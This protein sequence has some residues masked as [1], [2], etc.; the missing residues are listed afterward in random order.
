MP[1][2]ASVIIS[3]FTEKKPEK[4]MPSFKGID[5]IQQETVAG[6]RAVLPES[7][8]IA[9]D[10]ND[11]NLSQKM[12]A[13]ESIIPGFGNLN[14]QFSKN[15]Q[16]A[17]QGELPSDV[18]DM[19]K[20][21][22]AE[23]AA[24]GG[25]QGSQVADWSKAQN[26][27]LTSLQLMQQAQDTFM[28]WTQGAAVNIAP[29]QFNAASMFLSPETRIGVEESR[30]MNTFLA[31]IRNAAIDA[32]PEPWQ[33]RLMNTMDFLADTFIPVA[34]GAAGGGGGMMGSGGGAARTGT[35]WQGSGSPPAQ[36]HP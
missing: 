11:F 33:A 34:A 3:G 36:F 18:A 28:K 5:Q 16:S 6:N 23:S 13:L 27:G 9:G 10:I 22:T 2:I 24:R 14:Q 25:Y 21:Q 29:Q 26:L 32:A 17:L 20:R 19:I 4:V 1:S 31:N 8:R 12:G 35:T 7:L 15:L 30:S